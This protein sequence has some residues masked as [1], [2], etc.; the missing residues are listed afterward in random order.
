MLNYHCLLLV[1]LYFTS[2][3]T[4]CC[5]CLLTKARIELCLEISSL[6]RV[7]CSNNYTLALL[8][9]ILSRA[10]ISRVKVLVAKRSERALGAR[11]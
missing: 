2:L 3:V 8:V 10:L 5:L 6:G 4:K 9:Q 11:M 1:H 7:V